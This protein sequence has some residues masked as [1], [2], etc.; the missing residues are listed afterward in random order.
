[1]RA[2][3][4]GSC[5]TFARRLTAAAALF[6]PLVSSAAGLD[7]ADPSAA[8]E[9]LQHPAARGRAPSMPAQPGML[10]WRK[11]HETVGAYARGHADIVMWEARNPS[12]LG[13]DSQAH[14]QHQNKPAAP[15]A[16]QG[17]HGNHGMHG[18]PS[19]HNGHGG[20]G[21]HGA[22]GGHRP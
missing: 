21:A 11:A 16:G 3:P 1:M 17:Q 14:D 6:V 5:L 9:P 13:A 19:S 15:A 4:T 20:H 22:H 18:A 8:I 12:G 2:P 10:D 7:A